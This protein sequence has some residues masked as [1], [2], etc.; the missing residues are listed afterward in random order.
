MPLKINNKKKE[1]AITIDESIIK[2]H[3][4]PYVERQRVVMENV[5]NGAFDPFAVALA[6]LEL[7]VYG[8]ENVVG[9]DGE[10]VE[11]SAEYLQYLDGDA[12]LELIDKVVAPSLKGIINLEDKLVEKGKKTRERA[13]DDLGN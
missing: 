12:L 6:L 3:L 10:D 1:L 8:W 11:Y 7:M 9:D 4:I 13:E 5:H 2:Y